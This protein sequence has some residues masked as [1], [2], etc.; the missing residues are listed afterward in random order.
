MRLPWGTG[1][2][3][4][5]TEAG[6]PAC[7]ER[8]HTGADSGAYLRWASRSLMSITLP[9]MAALGRPAQTYKAGWAKARMCRSRQPCC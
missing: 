5:R 4:G 7:V 8:E 2:E 6:T 1:R 3:Q 9:R